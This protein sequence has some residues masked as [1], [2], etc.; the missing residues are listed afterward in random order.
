MSDDQALASASRQIAERVLA[1]PDAQRAA[2]LLEVANIQRDKGTWEELGLLFVE[3]STEINHESSSDS[4][5]VAAA[6]QLLELMRRHQPT[7]NS[8][9]LALKERARI[10][11]LLEGPNDRPAHEGSAKATSSNAAP[12][13]PNANTRNCRPSWRKVIGLPSV[14]AGSSSSATS[15]PVALS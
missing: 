15:S 11:S 13:P 5:A 10:L 7:D 3:V 6:R 2:V 12:R 9:R 4:K 8:Y 14:W 1:L